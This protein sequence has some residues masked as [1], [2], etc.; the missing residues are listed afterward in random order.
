[1]LLPSN[2]SEEGADVG[3]YDGVIEIPDV[4]T[5]SVLVMEDVI[6]DNEEVGDTDSVA[7][8][9]G[10]TDRTESTCDSFKSKMLV[11]VKEANAG[12]GAISDRNENWIVKEGVKS[13]SIKLPPS[14]WVTSPPNTDKGEQEFE[15]IDNSEKWLSFIFQPKFDKSKKYSHHALPTGVTPV[16]KNEDG[17]RVMNGWEFHYNGWSTSDTTSR[18]GTTSTNLFPNKGKGILD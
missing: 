6:K 18:S 16:P 5:T 13:R 2:D 8:A 12:E 10:L 7:S 15:D 9:D 3:S 4:V 1:M 14:D 11:L 17:D